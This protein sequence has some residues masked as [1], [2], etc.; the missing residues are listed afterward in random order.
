MKDYRTIKGLRSLPEFEKII[1]KITLHSVEKPI[2]L[3][4][5]EKIFLLSSAII[6]AKNYDID[7][8]Y[9]SYAEFAYYIILKYSIITN[10]FLPLYDFAINFGFYPIAKSLVENGQIKIC[11]IINYNI[12]A[13]IDDE[14]AFN[15]LIE[16]Y[17]QKEVRNSI[18]NSENNEICFVAP[19]SF[20]KSS[21]IIE[22]IKKNIANRNKISI[23]VPTKS[24]LTQTFR[25]LKKEISKRKIILHDEMYEGE[26]QFLS[27]LTQERAL[28]LLQKNEC[29]YFDTLYIDEAHNLFSKDN[30][31]IL[32]SRLI[33]LNKKR[34]PNHRVLYLSPLISNSDN[35]KFDIDQDIVEQKIDF[36]MKEPEIYELCLDSTVQKYNRFIDIFYPIDNE[37]SYLSYILKT[38]KRKNFF[39]LTSPKKIEC[40]TQ[41]LFT[42][43]PIDENIHPELEIVIENLKKYVHDDFYGIKYLKKG[44]IYLHGKLPD[45]IKEYLEYKFQ[46][47][48]NICYLVAN[49]VIL[50]GINLPIDSLYILSVYG[51]SEQR[52]M[53]LIGRVN[54]LNMIFNSTN[55]DYSLL[56]PNVH[57]INTVEFGRK[58]SNMS[59]KIRKLRT[60]K[61]HDEIDNPL[62]LEFD[63]DKFDTEKEEDQK[64]KRMVEKIVAEEKFVLA[65]SALTE[66]DKLKKKML[67]L[68]MNNIYNISESLC[69]LLLSRIGKLEGK[70]ENN[71]I[72]EIQKLFVKDLDSMIIDA[73]FAR[74]KNR[75]AVLYYDNFISISKK[76]SLKENIE[77][78]LKHFEIRKKSTDSLMYMGDSYGEIPYEGPNSK[79]RPVYVELKEKNSIELANLAIIKLK[80]END[81]VNY[82]LTK[83]FQLMLDYEIISK[84]YY[85]ILVYGTNDKKKLNLLKQG[86]T[87]NIINKLD[88]DNQIKNIIIDENNIIMS[89]EKFKEYK[90]KLDDFFRFEIDKYFS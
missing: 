51:L 88:S 39:F 59:N 4:K 8:R 14:F 63:M 47:L 57:F 25:T 78:I 42:Y 33:R 41:E 35:L 46:I 7:K 40:F 69:E 37:S 73:E 2:E 3:E 58:N 87:I 56:L 50:E 80:L 90:K 30:R 11:N 81:F 45:H 55:K 5:T 12:Q 32:L 13:R 68:G 16:T 77:N 89:N 15:N 44:I 52:L 20:G 53:N 19:T 83:F 79:G 17:S 34:N 72:F 10:D 43:L 82:T 75:E 22:D 60:G 76:K 27:V 31:T 36:N 38:K 70:I 86:L 9:Q 65:E 1:R 74:L 48:D 54:R 6:L 24:L 67:D 49:N 62:L 23:I 66:T 28:R 71:I 29:V 18:L 26:K 64:K 21:L 61:F 84:E 85:N